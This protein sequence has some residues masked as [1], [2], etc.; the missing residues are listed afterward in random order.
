MASL[1]RLGSACL[2]SMRRA[3]STLVDAVTITAR[4][5]PGARAG[6]EPGPA[7]A[8]AADFLAA[9]V[10][11]GEI[12]RRYVRKILGAG[13]RAEHESNAGQPTAEVGHHAGDRDVAPG[14]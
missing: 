3:A 5:R 12:D 14:V 1:T 13:E 10:G 9:V 6:P 7:P 2:N 8:A 11:T 4:A